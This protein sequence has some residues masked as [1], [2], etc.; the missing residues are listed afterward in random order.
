[1]TSPWNVIISFPNY[2]DATIVYT[3]VLSG[4]AWQPSAPLVNLQ[5]RFMAYPA[6]S[7]DCTTDTTQG[8][9]DL[10]TARSIQVIVIPRHN[11]SLNATVTFNLYDSSMVLVTSAVV[12][13]FPVLYPSGSLPFEDPH[14]F[15]G[16]LTPEEWALNVYPAPVLLVL[17]TA[18]LA[19]YVEFK[20]NDTG[21]TAGYIQLNRIFISQGWQPSINFD[22]GSS[23]QIQD[24]TLETVTLGMAS[25]YDQRTKQRVFNLSFPH[26]Q[27]NEAFVNALDMEM[28]LGRSGQ[29]FVSL[30]STDLV[31]LARISCICTMPTINP[32]AYASPNYH[33]TSFV[34]REVVA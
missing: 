22:Y 8:I 4:G 27:S 23:L 28:R 21:N 26:I 25:I 2:A 33:S 11:L 1:M 10:K 7:I 19:R 18:A 15:D 9:I 31:N 3:P 12:S 13:V 24:S 6:R 14:W 30:D 17:P 20:I 34:F 32:L 5:N 29:V 16:K